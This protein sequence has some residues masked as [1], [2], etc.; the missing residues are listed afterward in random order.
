MDKI[1][2]MKLVKESKLD[3]YE[4][5][6]L[7]DFIMCESD[8]AVSF[9]LNEFH[10]KDIASHIK[11]YKGKAQGIIYNPKVLTTLFDIGRQDNTTQSPLGPI[12]S[13]VG[14]PALAYAKKKLK[15]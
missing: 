12:I 13:A 14:E 5:L 7:L 1:A 3:K 2:V 9:V 8:E 15:R 10:L 11:K 6:F 4:K